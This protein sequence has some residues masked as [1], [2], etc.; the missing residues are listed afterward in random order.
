MTPEH[1]L[2]NNAVDRVLRSGHAGL[3]GHLFLG[4]RHRT[5]VPLLVP[6]ARD[7]PHAWCMGGT[8]SGKTARFLAPYAVQSLIAGR[9]VVVI[10]LKPDKGLFESLR[11]EAALQQVP[12]RWVDVT[13]GRWTY[14]FRPF[15][16]SHTQAQTLA[17][18]AET[19]IQALNLDYGAVYGG[20]YYTAMDELFVLATHTLFPDATTPA[21]VALRF[22]SP[23]P[24]KKVVGERGWED[25]SH[26]RAI[27][28]K[29]AG[30]TA[31]N[32]LPGAPGVTQDVLDAAIDLRQPFYHP[33]V[34]YF[35]LDAREFRTTSRAT[36]GLA[37]YNLLTAAKYVGAKAAVGVTLVL[38]ECQELVG[39]NL[40]VL[41][42]TARSLSIELVLAHQNLDQ[43]RRANQ[44]YRQTLEENTGLQVVFNP[45]G[46]GTREW[47][48]TTS[49]QQKYP[50]YS[51]DQ[52]VPRGFDPR[53]PA[54]QLPRPRKPGLVDF[55][56]VR[57]SERLGPVWDR[58]TLMN[59][60]AVPGLAMVRVARDQGF[61]RDRGQWVPVRTLFHVSKQVRDRWVYE[62]PWPGPNG[63]TVLVD[64]TSAYD[65][66]FDEPPPASPRG[67]E[68][69]EKLKR[70]R[71]ES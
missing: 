1:I 16:Q 46:Q 49:G 38:D 35:A 18:R 17:A 12:F 13:P 61:T 11:A 50:E 57:V 32:A 26:V 55:P 31:L 20:S 48:E 63:Q 64:R 7:S 25:S 4:Y 60:S 58:T 5:S 37:F 65:R 54:A 23:A 47:L 3:A 62:R 9:S 30:A 33:Q 69:K 14:V 10:D 28:A 67:V 19:T 44:D 34:I 51:W 40:T 42:E 27:Y 70:L 15:A 2:W 52:A 59:L 43:F 36:A 24:F 6:G 29:L 53:N 41:L 71:K 21:E 8:G 22:D 68:L 56:V 45:V 66:R 39:S